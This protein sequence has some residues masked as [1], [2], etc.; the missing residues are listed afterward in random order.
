K[1]ILECPECNSRRLSL[2]RKTK[3]Y[4]CWNC[5][6]TFDTPVKIDKMSPRA[7]ALIATLIM[8]AIT[9]TLAAILY[10]MVI[11]MKPAIYLYT[12]KEEKEQLKLKVKGA[13]TTR[14][15]FR[16]GISSII[17]DNLVLKNG[18]IFTNKKSFDYLFYESKNVMPEHEN[19]GW[20]QKRQNDALTWNQAPIDKNDLS[21]ILR[22]ILTK[23]GL[24]E[25][26]INDFIEYWFDDDMKIFFG[27][28]EFTFGIYPISLEEVD[29]IFSIETMLEYPEYIRVQL[30]VKEIEDG[31]VL[32][33]PKF[34]LITRSEYAL[35]E[36]GMIKR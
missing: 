21:E 12:P 27:Q 33:E 6:A 3:I 17:W 8:V 25:N 22:N 30:L 13:I 36:W 32:A 20:I 29:R 23:Y 19:T 2:D 18:K 1:M 31:E 26:E 15:P 11:S 34:P 24:F 16:E 14:I 5:K 10:S 35:H 4:R 7:L 28:D 9:V